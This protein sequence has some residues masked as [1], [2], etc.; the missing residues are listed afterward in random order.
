MTENHW[1]RYKSTKSLKHHGVL[2]IIKV[3]FRVHD[4]DVLY[5]YIYKYKRENPTPVDA[6]EKIKKISLSLTHTLS[7]T[8]SYSFSLLPTPR[9]WAR[10]LFFRSIEQLLCKGE[11]GIHGAL[12]GRLVDFLVLQGFF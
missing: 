2:L 1:M 12:H 6:T 10:D 11:H 8:L 7:P 5:I 4:T 3:H 9:V